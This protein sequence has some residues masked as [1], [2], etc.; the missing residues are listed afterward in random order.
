MQ[1]IPIL[2]LFFFITTISVFSQVSIKL[3]ECNNISAST[4]SDPNSVNLIVSFNLEKQ[5]SLGLWAIEKRNFERKDQITFRSLSEGTYR[6]KAV[7]KSSETSQGEGDIIL[8]SNIIEVKKCSKEGFGNKISIMPNPSTNIV[9][10]HIADY[11][12]NDNMSI[13]IIDFSGRKMMDIPV[14]QNDTKVTVS[15]FANGIYQLILLDKSSSRVA[16]TKFIVNN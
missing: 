2:F 12:Q 8:I 13:S 4:E 6:V 10:V 3:L 9:S 15:T 14:V 1:K 11:N 7:R 5:I 16:E